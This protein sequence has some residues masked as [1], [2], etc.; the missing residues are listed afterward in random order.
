MSATGESADRNTES[1]RARGLLRSLWTIVGP[2]L[3][4]LM[5]CAL[6]TLY[7]PSSP[8]FLTWD[9]WR[10]I[11]VQTVILGTVSLGTT[12][13]MIAGG[14]DLSVGS[15][16]ALITV[17]IVQANRQLGL[18]LPLALAFGVLLGAGCGLLNGLLITSLRVVPF[19]ITLGTLK[20]FRG[21]AKWWAG[22]L[23]IYA[24]DATHRE[25]PWLAR[26]L[27][28]TLRPAH[29]LGEAPGGWVPDTARAL[30]RLAPGVWLLL[31]LSVLVAVLLRYTVLGRHFQAVGSNEATAR[32]CG[33]RVPRT[34]VLAYVVAGL[35][36]GMAGV[37]QF[38]Y[39]HGA[40]EPTSG[41]GLELKAI[42]AVVIGG[43]SLGGGEGTVL[44]TLVG[45][46]I[47]QVL[48]NGCTHAGI[49]NAIQDILVG[50]IIV[51]AVAIDQV[52]RDP[53]APARFWKTLRRAHG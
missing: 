49:P 41:E 18:D 24:F 10:T 31:A 34:K 8:R 37:C 47:I 26:M 28:S 45:C 17:G 12:L 13:V 52:R 19:I 14:I 20:V 1:S 43:G 22:N 30:S 15:A 5:I 11:A 16:V 25:P 6:F 40:G 9:N 39:S 29:W 50:A 32:L 23:S 48:E 7:P 3:G 35:L 38:A 42:A 51:I 44:G 33:V 2:F 21:L 27:S 46:L 4:L 36:T 53:S